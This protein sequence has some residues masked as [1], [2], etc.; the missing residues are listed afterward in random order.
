M[1]H[2]FVYN[3][4]GEALGVV[5]FVKVATFAQRNLHRLDVVCTY[6]T[7]IRVVRHSRHR[8]FRS[9]REETA[10][11]SLP[12]E[13]DGGRVACRGYSGQVSYSV[14]HLL[15]ESCPL[16]LVLILSARQDRSN[17]Q[18]LVWLKH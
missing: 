12:G 4:Y 13:G 5:V 1:G 18:H 6:L 15:V 2:S 16:C 10:G 17:R 3:R 7:M 11:A 8:L 14:Q 9:F